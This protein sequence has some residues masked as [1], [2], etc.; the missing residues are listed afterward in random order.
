MVFFKYLKQERQ[1][2]H[3]VVKGFFLAISTILV[4]TQKKDDSGGS[5]DQVEAFLWSKG[6]IK[7]LQKGLEKTLRISQDAAPRKNK[8]L[9]PPQVDL[10]LVH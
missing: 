6:Y 2:N 10:C 7:N 5:L 3:K 9:V 8:F 4:F 1:I